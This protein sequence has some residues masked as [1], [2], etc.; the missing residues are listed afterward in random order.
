MTRSKDLWLNILHRDVLALGLP[1]PHYRRPLEELSSF[2]C[3]TLALHALNTDRQLS[4]WTDT[5]PCPL[6]IMH[7]PKSVTWVQFIHDHWLLIA[8]SDQSSSLLSLWDIFPFHRAHSHP[9][10][11]AEVALCGPVKAGYVDCQDDDTV[12]ALEVREE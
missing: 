8:S 5:T 3:E 4:T 10:L 12:I 1:T 2:E 7:G 9:R 6:T 11:V